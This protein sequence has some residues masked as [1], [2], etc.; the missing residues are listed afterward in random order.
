M[1]FR[2]QY[3]LHQKGYSVQKSVDIASGELYCSEVSS[4]CI[5][6]VSVQKSVVVA[7]D[8]L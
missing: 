3:S 8:G 1:V 7:S 2:S 4:G 6:G 5:R